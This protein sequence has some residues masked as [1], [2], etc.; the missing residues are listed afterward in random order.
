MYGT[1]ILKVDLTIPIKEYILGRKCKKLYL[2]QIKLRIK[3]IGL[4]FYKL[5]NLNV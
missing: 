1:Y 5:K 4:E 3:K 2:L